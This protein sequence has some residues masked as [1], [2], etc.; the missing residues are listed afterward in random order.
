[1]SSSNFG[2]NLWLFYTGNCS[3]KC[4]AIRSS[5]PAYHQQSLSNSPHPCSPNF[6]PSSCFANDAFATSAT[7]Q[8]QVREICQEISKIAVFSLT[9]HRLN[10]LASFSSTFRSNIQTAVRQTREQTNLLDDN[11]N[12]APA[13]SKPSH[14]ISTLPKMKRVL[15]TSSLQNILPYH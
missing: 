8:T 4:A 5:G 13:I 3:C 9:N 11:A 10:M 14:G 15:E 12:I 6:P 1:M 2:L 7:S